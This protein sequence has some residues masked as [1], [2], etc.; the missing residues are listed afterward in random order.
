MA[1]FVVEDDPGAEGRRGAFTRGQVSFFHTSTAPSSRSTARR[2][3]SWQLQPCRRSRYQ[4]PGIVYR[5]LNFAVIRPAI[6]ARVHRWSSQPAA[7]GPASSSRSSSTSWSRPSRHRA[8]CPFDARPGAPP[9]CHAAR[10]RCTDRSDTRSSAAI[11]ATATRR[12]N[13]STAASRTSSRRRRPS[14]VKPPPC[15]YLTHRAYRRKPPVSAPLQGSDMR[16]PGLLRKRRCFHEVPIG[17]ARWPHPPG[18]RTFAASRQNV[19]PG[20]G[21]PQASRQRGR[22]CRTSPSTVATNLVTVAV[23]GGPGSRSEN[24]RCPPPTRERVSEPMSASAAMRPRSRS[25]AR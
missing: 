20:A 21:S 15:P 2:A 19:S 5:T 25:S 18:A 7:A 6:R 14:A 3:P 24:S 13:F 4:T 17:P 9:A 22:R 23:P 11:S 10:H 1:G 16:P 8:A 12:S